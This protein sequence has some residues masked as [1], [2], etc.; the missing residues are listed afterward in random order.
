MEGIYHGN[1]KKLSLNQGPGHTILCHVNKENFTVTSYLVK[2]SQRKAILRKTIDCTNEVPILVN[3]Q[4]LY[5]DSYT[6]IIKRNAEVT[7]AFSNIQEHVCD[8]NKNSK[9][10]CCLIQVKENVWFKNRKTPIE[11]RKLF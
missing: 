11:I 1:D 4:I 7:N 5:A 6:G 10:Y 2:C 8:E 9:Y 3:G